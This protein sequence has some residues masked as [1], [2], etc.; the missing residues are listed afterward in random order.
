MGYSGWDQKELGIAKL[1]LILN[2]PMLWQNFNNYNVFFSALVII[3]SSP[4]YSM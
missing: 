4:C 3:R 2:R 1:Y